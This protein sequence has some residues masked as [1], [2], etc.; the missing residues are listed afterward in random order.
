MQ[1]KKDSVK[2]SLLDSAAK[3]FKTS[4]F[5]K[6]SIRDIVKDAGTTIGNFYNYF[7]NKDAIFLALTEDLYQ[8]FVTLIDHHGLDDR[9]MVIESNDLEVWRKAIID[10]MTPLL[11]KLDETFLLLVENENSQFGGFKERLI[12]L[13]SGHFTEHITEFSPEYKYPNLGR[14]IGIGLLSSICEVIRTEKDTQKRIDL[15]VELIIYF[16]VGILGL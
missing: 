2:Q 14:L 8:D 12:S 13:L 10:L 6:A 11:V 5:E 4:G 1:I 16:S 9:E 3:H 15:I 7:E